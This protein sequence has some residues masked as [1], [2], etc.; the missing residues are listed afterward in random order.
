MKLCHHDQHLLKI[1]VVAYGH[2]TRDGEKTDDLEQCIHEPSYACR[3]C[4]GSGSP[5][6]GVVCA[7]CAVKQVWESDPNYAGKRL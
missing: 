2:I 6:P 5:Y 3:R 1:K 4:G 7:R